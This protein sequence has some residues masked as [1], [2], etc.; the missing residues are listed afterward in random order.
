MKKKYKKYSKRIV[1]SIIAIALL[2][3]I[4]VPFVEVFAQNRDIEIDFTDGTINGNVITYTIGETNVTATLANTLTLT[5]GKITI[6]DEEW[7]TSI[8]ISD[9]YDA[10][11]MQIRI[12]A[13]DGFQTTYSYNSGTLTRNGEGGLPNS[14]KFVI[15]EKSNSQNPGDDQG[16]GE[17]FD[18]RAVVLWSCGSGDSGVCYHE[19][20]MVD[21]N[22][23]DPENYTEA[24]DPEIGDFGDGNSTFFKDTDIEADNKPGTTFDVNAEYR[25]WY[26]TDEFNIW[27]ELYKIAN[28]MDPDDEINWDEMDRELIMGAPNQHIGELVEEAA[29]VCDEAEDQ[30]RCINL[31][32]AQENHEIWTHELQPVG[33]PTDNNA[34]VS[35]GDRNF[36][37]VI[38]NDDFKGITTGDLTGLNYYPARWTSPFLRTDQYD[39]SD[40]DKNHPTLLDSILLE[41][42]VNI[43]TLP[44]NNYAIESIEALDVPEGAVTITKVN[45]HKFRL[46]FSSNFYDHVVFKI[47][48][49]NNETSYI[50]VKRYTVDA[51]ISRIDDHPYI[52]ADFYFDRERSYTDFDITA[53][54]LYK[55]GTTE[56][57]SLTAQNGVDNGLGDYTE[58][59]E[60]DQESEELHDKGKGLKLSTFIYQL[61]DGA[62]RNIKDIYLN[63]EYKG[64]DAS[65][66]AGAYAGSGEGTLANIYHP[67][68][69]E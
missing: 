16:Q 68:E 20:G 59:F 43:D 41:N 48:D 27:Q 33:E 35:Y 49:T 34:Y 53:K 51:T 61:E 23:C 14:F 42:T 56:T 4:I 54:I 64:S 19:F 2:V 11:T 50:Q 15:E 12:Y 3:K 26:L 40:T 6:D 7:L 1:A 44:Y 32:A 67:E 13:E 30:E 38:Y 21:P 55:D 39:V 57:V 28:N 25:E 69:G 22:N 45:S 31:Y 5:D 36:K 62:E 63:A 46:V 52:T 65:T 47:T 66:Y 8:T 60:Q 17:G 58:G 37:V 24:C 9:N 10:E 29:E 18:G